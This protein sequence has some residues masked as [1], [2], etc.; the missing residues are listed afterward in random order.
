MGVTSIHIKFCV[1]RVDSVGTYKMVI[2]HKFTACVIP[3]LYPISP[4]S[5]VEHM[6]LTN[7]QQG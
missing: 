5:F 3:Y 6:N 7:S 4:E 1:V 2:H